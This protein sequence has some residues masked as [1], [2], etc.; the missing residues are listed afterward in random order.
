MCLAG[1][2]EER[3]KLDRGKG[4]EENYFSLFDRNKIGIGKEKE[5]ICTCHSFII[6]S[7]HKWEENGRR[8]SHST[9]INHYL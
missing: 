8:K 2:K 3:R 7:F 5:W 6:E 4:G 9:K 1:G